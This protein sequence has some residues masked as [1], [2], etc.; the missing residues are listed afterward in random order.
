MASGVIKAAAKLDVAVNETDKAAF[1]LASNTNMFDTFPPGQHATIII[2]K[3]TD[4]LGLTMK[5]NAKVNI[6]KAT[7]CKLKPMRNGLGELRKKV[8]LEGLKLKATDNI[9]TNNATAIPISEPRPSSKEKSSIALEEFI[10]PLG[11]SKRSYVNAA[12]RKFEHPL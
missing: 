12:L 5:H 4:G 2:P 10:R 11:T 3:A 8:K 1:P 7:N 6:G 9:I